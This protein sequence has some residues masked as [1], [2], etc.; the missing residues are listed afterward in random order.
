METCSLTRPDCRSER[1]VRRRSTVEVGCFFR[2]VIFRPFSPRP[3]FRHNPIQRPCDNE[4]LSL[5]YTTL[6][7]LFLVM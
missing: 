3:F 7:I 6:A 1:G 5:T 4:P 2:Y